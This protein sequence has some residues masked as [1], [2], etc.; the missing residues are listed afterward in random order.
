[1]GENITT[2]GVELLALPTG[3]RLWLG[4]GA[5]VVLTGLRN[6]CVQLERLHTG[7]MAATLGR[8]PDGSLARKAGVMAIVETG[9]EVF[10]SD[11]IDVELPAGERRP[12][13]PV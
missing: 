3:S 6:P 8:R 7:L 4:A 2:R 10:A 5:V 9:G 11:A 13:A 12:L 1:M